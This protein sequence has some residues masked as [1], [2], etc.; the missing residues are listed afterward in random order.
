MTLI[1]RSFGLLAALALL[2]VATTS[3]AQETTPA[4]AAPAFS[5]AKLEAF[6]N[7]AVNV[8]HVMRSWREKVQGAQSEDEQ[9]AMIE[10]AN[11]EIEQAIAATDGITLDEYQAIAAAA[12]KDPAFAEELKTRVLTKLRAA[13]A[14]P[15]N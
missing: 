11:Q 15:Q 2:A 14:P 7:A 6:A 5:E 1:R 8:S 13:T 4:P 10:K 9:T 12:Q 3:Q